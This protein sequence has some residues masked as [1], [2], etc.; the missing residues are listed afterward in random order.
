MN[1]SVLSVG[2]FILV[3]S[4]FIFNA[5]QEDPALKE[6]AASAA[7][8]QVDTG[9]IFSGYCEKVDEA[10]APTFQAPADNML[11]VGDDD[12]DESAGKIFTEPSHCGGNRNQIGQETT[13]RLI[14]RNVPMSVN[15]VKKNEFVWDDSSCHFRKAEFL[16]VNISGID[17]SK[18]T[19]FYPQISGEIGIDQAVYSRSRD[20]ESNLMYFIDYGLIFLVHKN[21]DG[22]YTELQG[23][24]TDDS[25]EKFYL[26]DVYQDI[27]SERPDLPAEALAC[28]TAITPGS[29]AATGSQIIEPGQQSAGD[30][31][32][33]QIKY[34]VFGN[35]VSSN[36]TQIVNG[37]GVHCKPAVYLYPQTKQL[38]NVQVFPK[39]ELIH[40]DPP[41]QP[42]KGWT[43]NANPTGALF[44][45]NDQPI[46]NNYL[47]YESK[48]FDSEI[49]KP[50][51]GWVIRPNELE[52][53]LNRIL[54]QLGLNQKEQQDFM[55]YWLTKLPDSPYYFVG[56][57]EK[58]QRDYLETLKVTPAPETSIRFSLFFE[59]LD[60]PK[61]VEEPTINTPERKGYTLVDWGGLIKLHPGTPFTCSQ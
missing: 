16:D 39:G 29:V 26:V 55:D 33:L 30:E 2:L 48:L 7:K 35:A 4:F 19:A 58:P 6:Q 37:W 59:M 61:V 43:V 10:T 42:G 44:T 22:G 25:N 23:T 3:L 11:K 38:I 57:I 60:S 53:L 31:N 9:S 13:Y 36:P 12:I 40:T 5:P 47:Y 52:N 56:L 20:R 1:Y 24:T 27:D 15:D 49:Q 54:P 32:Q 17:S 51:K 14:R 46:T 34:F 21:A 28:D 18:F 50:Q 41:Y 45:M 8:S